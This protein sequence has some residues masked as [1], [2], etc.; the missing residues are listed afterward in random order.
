M[1]WQQGSGSGRSCGW[2]WHYANWWQDRGDR[3]ASAWWHD[4]SYHG[5][6]HGRT[7][8]PWHAPAAVAA[9][10]GTAEAP[11]AR[12][13][14]AWEE[15]ASAAAAA[16]APAAVAAEPASLA[17]VAAEF[18]E[19]SGIDG[20]RAFDVEFFR[21]FQPF[22]RHWSQHN[23]ALKYFREEYENKEDPMNSPECFFPVEEP[24]AVAASVPHVKGSGPQWEFNYQEQIPWDWKEMV[25][26]MRFEDIH[27]VVIGPNENNRGLVA[28]SVAPRPNSYDHARQKMLK[29]AGKECPYKL[30]CWDFV[31]HRADGTGIRLHPRRTQTAVEVFVAEGHASEVQPPRRGLGASDGR[32]TFRWYKDWDQRPALRFDPL[33]RPT[34]PQG[35]G[36][37]D[38]TGKGKGK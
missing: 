9:A 32:G 18:R 19:A 20:P 34:G 31:L 28:C 36:E 21:G 1:A 30:P 17:V 3:D 7:D 37:G 25:A 6:G 29:D 2:S 35:K 12:A 5:A 13:R 27:K 24:A 10:A 14:A 38:G 16:V 26:Q 4:S 11:L 8:A 33:K 23:E 15:T 22:T